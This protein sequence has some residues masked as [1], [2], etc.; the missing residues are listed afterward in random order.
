MANP[1]AIS[2]CTNIAVAEN[3]ATPP[4]KTDLTIPIQNH[5]LL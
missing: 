2:G 1:N 3:H 4:Q 5:T